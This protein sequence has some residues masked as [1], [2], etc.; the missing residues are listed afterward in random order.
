MKKLVLL[1]PL[2]FLG[3]KFGPEGIVKP[4]KEESIPSF[5]QVV[6]KKFS[7]FDIPMECMQRNNNEDDKVSGYIHCRTCSY[8]VFLEHEGENK[9]TYCGVKKDYESRH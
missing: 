5:V 6:P 9:C 1:I 4:A 8:G 3:A 7:Q 2:I